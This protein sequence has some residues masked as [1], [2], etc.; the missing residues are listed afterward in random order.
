MTELITCLG[1]GKGTWGHVARLVKEEEWDKVLI[2]ADNFFRGK[3]NFDNAEIMIIDS[4][5]Y[6]SLLVED[7]KNRLKDKIKG[8]EVAV[9]L[10]SGSGKEHM[11]II[12]ALLK[13]GLGI[14]LV[15]LTPNGVK[16][17]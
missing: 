15:A 10:F 2:I 5:K 4:N 11:A 14:R 7:I 17:V 6:L 13:L 12:A 1:S 16:E 3:I 9:N 8:T